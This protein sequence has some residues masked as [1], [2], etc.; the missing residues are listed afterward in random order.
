MSQVRGDVFC[1]SPEVWAGAVFP[2]GTSVEPL[3]LEDIFLAFAR[4]D[5]KV[6]AAG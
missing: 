5:A 6:A 2:E 3:P 1:A 4:S